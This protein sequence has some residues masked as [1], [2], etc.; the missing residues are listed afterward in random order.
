M[1][2][3][4]KAV[5]ATELHVWA[6]FE[7]LHYHFRGQPPPAPRF[8]EAVWRAVFA[9]PPRASLTRPLPPAQPVLRDLDPQRR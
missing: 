7:T 8:E 6:C 2:E 5:E 1:L 4:E 3:I 9:V